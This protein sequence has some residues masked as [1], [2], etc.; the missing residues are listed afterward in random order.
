MTADGSSWREVEQWLSASHAEAGRVLPQLLNLPT[1]MLASELARRPEL[2]TVGMI[3][4]LTAVAEE[5]LDR[6]PLRACELAAIAVESAARMEVPPARVSVALR[7]QAQAWITH[8]RALRG[9]GRIGEAAE[10]IAMARELFQQTPA[11]EWSLAKADLLEAQLLHDLGRREEALPLVRRASSLFAFHYD[12]DHYL[13]GRMIETW[14]LWSAGDGAAATEVWRATVEE[15]EQYGNPALVAHLERKM[16]VFELRHGSDEEAARLLA[17]A[18]ATFVGEGLTGEAIRARWNLA[19]AAAAL[20]RINEAISELHKVRAELVAMG[21][22]GEAALA[23][24]A[25]LELLL[26]A[27]RLDEATSLV[28][29]LAFLFRDAGM[30]T[31]A[32]EAFSY[33]RARAGQGRLTQDDVTHVRRFFEDLPQQPYMWFRGLD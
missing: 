28:D 2:R 16:G 24:M 9:V 19:E 31:N 13:Q 21:R 18:L 17:S 1:P 27:G 12:H 32:L 29:I 22:L 26:A 23:S 10:A 3:Q 11:N 15:A 30:A 6:F 33:L 8:A 14:M 7:I 5:A 25:G 4:R 20:G